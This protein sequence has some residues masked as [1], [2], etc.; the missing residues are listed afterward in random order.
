[1]K[2][3][4]RLLI[5]SLALLAAVATVSA[6]KR[7]KTPVCAAKDIP[8]TSRSCV[9]NG[10]T[11]SPGSAG[12]F[13]KDTECTWTCNLGCK[14]VGGPRKRTCK[15]RP[16]EWKKQ[17]RSN[18]QFQKSKGIQCACRRC[19][20]GPGSWPGVG[21]STDYTSGPPYS[22]GT[23]CNYDCPPGYTTGAGS[24]QRLC[25]NSIWRDY[26]DDLVCTDIDECTD[27]TDGCAH[28]CTN[29]EGSYECSCNAGY[30]LAAD[31]HACDDVD[32][33]VAGTSGC[34]QTCTNTIGS[35]TCSCDNAGYVLNAD[36]HACDDVDECTD[37]TDG[38]AHDCTNT[39]G[40]YTCSC[41]EGYILAADAHDCEPE[42]TGAMPTV[43]PTDDPSV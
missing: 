2:S 28:V 18:G 17:Q 33:C 10:A 36:G 37:D 1:M 15:G 39:I 13:L 31:D 20:S 3:S 4:P 26:M 38:C 23:L 6:K 16:G 9:R 5:L 25:F 12:N 35:Y 41:M 14:W 27:G 11:V 42:P 7:K 29:T 22:A 19:D 8:N 24:R 21:P 30:V 32:E 34:A 40:S 43:M